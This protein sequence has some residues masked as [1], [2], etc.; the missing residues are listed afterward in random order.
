MRRSEKWFSSFQKFLRRADDLLSSEERS[1]SFAAVRAFN[2]ENREGIVLLVGAHELFL[3][4]FVIKVP[5]VD[6]DPGEP[7]LAHRLVLHL[8]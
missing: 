3:L 2:F 6:L 8:S 1:G 4:D 7:C 5:F